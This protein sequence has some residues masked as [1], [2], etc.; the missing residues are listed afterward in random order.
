MMN[1]LSRMEWKCIAT[2][3]HK[4]F[5]H[6]YPPPAEEPVQ[7]QPPGEGQS[8]EPIAPPPPPTTEPPAAAPPPPPPPPPISMRRFLSGAVQ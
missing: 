7:W 6:E 5:P 1:E 4:H 2:Y 8:G 3:M